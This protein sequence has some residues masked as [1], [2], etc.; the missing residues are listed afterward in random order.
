MLIEGMDTEGAA[1]GGTKGRQKMLQGLFV[2]PS[3]CPLPNCGCLWGKMQ[4]FSMS[5]KTYIVFSGIYNAHL[6]RY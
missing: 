5:I 6:D 1:E 4:S 3:L 2:D